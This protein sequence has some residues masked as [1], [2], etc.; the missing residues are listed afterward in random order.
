MAAREK[1]LSCEDGPVAA[2]AD[3]E[4]WESERAVD[5]IWTPR[6]RA[7]PAP[8]RALLPSERG[9]LVQC[10]SGLAASEERA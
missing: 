1:G 5:R 9:L 6:V 8:A 3:L 10:V 2:A 7:R 4:K